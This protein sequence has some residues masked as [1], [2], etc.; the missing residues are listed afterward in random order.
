MISQNCD[1]VNYVDFR[2]RLAVGKALGE[3]SCEA[4]KSPRAATRLLSLLSG[5]EQSE[6]GLLYVVRKFG[7]QA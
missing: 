2:R 6:N 3:P 5:V 7:P 1:T 4:V